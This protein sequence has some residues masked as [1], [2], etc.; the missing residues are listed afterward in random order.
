MPQ[1]ELFGAALALVVAAVYF[2]TRR[3]A[4][5]GGHFAGVGNVLADLQK[6]SGAVF[7]LMAGAAHFLMQRGRQGG[8][9]RFTGVC[10]ELRSGTSNLLARLQKIFAPVFA[11][12]L[13]AVHFLTQLVQ[14]RP[15]PVEDDRPI[16]QLMPPGTSRLFF[17]QRTSALLGAGDHAKAMVST[18]RLPVT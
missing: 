16:W 15:P 18:R 13:A 5:S 10:D 1:P 2:L 9:Q 8:A 7:A 3:G 17:E 4:A 11:E 14:R 12:M 6:I